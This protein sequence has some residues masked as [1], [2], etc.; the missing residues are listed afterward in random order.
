MNAPVQ[1]TRS[2][3]ALRA[4]AWLAGTVVVVS[5]LVPI[6]AVA[7]AGI[8]LHK[9]MQPSFANTQARLE[10]AEAV[11]QFTLPK[12]S[13]I[14]PT[15]AGVAFNNL[16]PSGAS[17]TRF[18]FRQVASRPPS[19][20]PDEKLA[21][22]LFP[23]ARS[24]LS[25]GGPSATRILSLAARGEV[26]KEELEF[27]GDVA[28]ARVW[29]DVEIVGRAPAVDIIGGR[30]VIPFPDDAYVFAMPLLKFSAT[31]DL[32]YAGVSRAAYYLA[33]NQKDS[34]E[35]ALRAV[36]SLGFALSDNGT[37]I[38]D[39]LIGTVIVGIGRQALVEFYTLT[40]NPSGVVLQTRVDSIVDAH[41]RDVI[42]LDS[43]VPGRPRDAIIAIVNSQ[44]VPR[45]MRFE[46]L[47][48]LA[49]MPCTN[50][51]ELIMGPRQDIVETFARAKKELARFP[52]E[53]ALI[54]L[55]SKLL[56]Q[57]LPRASEDAIGPSLAIGAA[58]IASTIFRNPRFAACTSYFVQ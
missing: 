47:N 32:A 3:P 23:T 9:F 36:T 48:T 31:K 24:T 2:N 50:V 27:L 29:R 11:R 46:Y 26:S 45:G 30:F 42:H 39:Q 8:R 49:L 57:P 40:K 53:V 54:E 12:D 25:S 22:E 6:I 7:T 38:I 10:R 34:A 33:R 1:R 43:V 15:Q 28:H 17:T 21:P 18:V 37:T 4:L 41:V 58:S 20:W 19:P 14:T 16:Q 55:S 13:S 52:S 44:L 56:D 5:L 35:S 51:R